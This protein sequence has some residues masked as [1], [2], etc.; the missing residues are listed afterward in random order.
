VK[1]PTITKSKKSAAGP[2][3]NREH[4]HFSFDV[5]GIVHCEFVP[6]NTKVNSD[7]YCDVLGGLRENATKDRNIGATT[8][9]SFITTMRP[10]TCP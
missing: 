4:A 8:T 3:F 9:G 2:E 10:P 5:K 1:E 7:I 6:H